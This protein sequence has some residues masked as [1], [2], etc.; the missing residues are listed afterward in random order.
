MPSLSASSSLGGS[1]GGCSSDTTS[2]FKQQQQQAEERKQ[3]YGA[4]ADLGSLG[5][6]NGTKSS[7]RSTGYRG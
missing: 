7:T 4:E 2:T 5:G 1:L 6:A 3:L